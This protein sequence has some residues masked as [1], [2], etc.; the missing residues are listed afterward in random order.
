MPP[1][2]RFAKADRKPDG[3]KPVH[4]GGARWPADP[5]RA[6]L[7]AAVEHIVR[8]WSDELSRVLTAQR[9]HARAQELTARYGESF[10]AAYREAYSPENAAAD[11]AVVETLSAQHTLAIHFYR[12]H[13]NRLDVANLKVCGRPGGIRTPN[14][15]FWRPALCQLELLACIKLTKRRS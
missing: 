13:E 1:P 2:K 14:I 10:S 6:T 8:S 12:A 7:E 4:G 15:R 5:A 3:S 9:G 11:L